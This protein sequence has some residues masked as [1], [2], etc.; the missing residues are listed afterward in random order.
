MD[1]KYSQIVHSFNK[2]LRNVF[3]IL[4]ALLLVL[5]PL[6][7][8]YA[9]RT[10]KVRTPS[11]TSISSE[12]TTITVSW[13]K[14][15]S[16]GGYQIKV[17]PKE[18]NGTKIITIKNGKSK[19]TTVRSLKENIQYRIRVRAYAIKNGKKHYS[20]WSKQ[21]T[22]KTKKSTVAKKAANNSKKAGNSKTADESELTGKTKTT[23]SEYT[24]TYC[25]NGG[26]QAKGQKTTYKSSD[27]DFALKNPSREGYTF[28][29]WF[30]SDGTEKAVKSIAKGTTGD[31]ALT[32]RW[33][34]KK[35]SYVVTSIVDPT[36]VEPGQRIEVC[37]YCGD[38]IVTAL[39]A[40]GHVY[41]ETDRT[42]PTCAAEGSITSECNRCGKEKSTS[43]PATSKHSLCFHEKIDATCVKTGTL[44]YWSCDT[45]GGLFGD[46]FACNPLQKSDIITE[47]TDDHTLVHVDG[48]E[49]TCEKSGMQEHYECTTC[50]KVFE[51]ESGVIPSS[52]AALRIY[53]KGHSYSC[54]RRTAATCTSKGVETHRCNNCGSEKTYTTAALGHTYVSK[55]VETKRGYKCSNGHVFASPKTIMKLC[56]SASGYSSYRYVN[57][58]PTCSSSSYS[59]NMVSTYTYACS[60]CGASKY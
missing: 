33:K 23:D 56:R 58:C 12:K 46:A 35:H 11:I 42:N 26:T 24:I 5:S 60:R 39:S 28:L 10:T 43:I 4:I 47:I 27:A 18:K 2:S 22:I 19:K 59:A 25:L 48:Y 36:C 1:N 54:V 50:G 45:C 8:A 6:Q 15:A 37:K 55:K 38:E 41:I 20:G 14:V 32:A 57:V 29:G 44:A 52:L 34:E 30:L 9:A 16:A 17:A 49:A 7:S 53:S 13:K 51:D 21:K 31:L 3:V 40:L